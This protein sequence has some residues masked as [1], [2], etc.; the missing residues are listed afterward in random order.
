MALHVF[1]TLGRERQE[2]KPLNP[3]KVGMYVCGPTVYGHAHLGH[4]KSYV[5]F[6][7][8]LRY[9]RHLGYDVTYV[10]NITD[11]GHL[12][13]D[14]QGMADEGEDKI[15]REARRRGLHPMAVVEA[16]KQS[17]LEDMDRLNVKRPDVMPHAAAHIPEQI[18]MIEKLIANGHAYAVGSKVF[19]D[20]SSFAEYGKLSNRRVEDMSG[21]A[22][23]DVD[24]DKRHEGDFY[25]WRPAAPEHILQWS[26]PWGRG[27]PGWHLECSVMSGK[28]LGETLDIHGGGL[29]NQFPHHECEIAQSE[30]ANG[31]PFVRYWLHNGM[32]TVDGTK[33]GK[34]LGNFITLKELFSGEHARL[35]R[36]YDPLAVRQFIL[37][38]HYRGPVD[39]SN[40]ALGAA[41]SGSRRLREAVLA[42]R[43][44]AKTAPDGDV[45]EGIR[46]ALDRTRERFEEAMNDDF[47]TAAALSAVFELVKQTNTAL[48]SGV[49][50]GD[51]VAI[52]ET[53]RALGGD[54]LGLVLD[55]Y[56]EEGAGG[57]ELLTPVMQLLIDMRAE[58]RKAKNFE[59]A[60]QIR[61]RLTEAGVTLED[62]AGGTTWRRV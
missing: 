21:G 37:N 2:F 19:F 61:D 50:K 41:E 38:S 59:L 4:G 49:T 20:I 48:T 30:A 46:T 29:E 44:A 45:S 27:Y 17:Y 39:F 11:V 25:L 26:S 34:S 36:A 40:E 60:D 43:E 53:F 51:A 54:V 22:R 31:C 8:I 13:E 24:P 35:D 57:G 55:K 23:V 58:A 15:I 3:P 52:D 7:V 16:F 9:L 18:E 62:K 6:D 14:T 32:V 1:N 5:S 56:P 33:M 10:Q 42:V 12:T 47:N 28:Y